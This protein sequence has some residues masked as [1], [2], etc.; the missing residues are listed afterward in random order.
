MMLFAPTAV[1]VKMTMAALAETTGLTTPGAPMAA[2]MN[3]A[4]ATPTALM[5]LPILMG[6]AE[7]YVWT[8]LP[9]ALTRGAA[10]PTAVASPR[11]EELCSRKDSVAAVGER[12]G[13]SWGTG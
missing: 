11:R 13:D 5:L 1:M 9:S 3:A 4:V 7:T 8:V 10:F 6:Q 2:T 12:S